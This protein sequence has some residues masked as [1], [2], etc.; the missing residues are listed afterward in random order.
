[1]Y[2]GKHRLQ[3]AWLDECLKSLV[4]ED[5]ATGNMVNNSKHC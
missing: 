4:S 3:K 2:F 5:S 1:M